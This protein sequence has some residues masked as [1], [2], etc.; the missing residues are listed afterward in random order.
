MSGR[1]WPSRGGSLPARPIKS[2]GSSARKTR[3][4]PSIRRMKSPRPANSGRRP[5]LCRRSS[6]RRSQSRRRKRNRRR[7]SSRFRTKL[8]A[9]EHRPA[10][11]PGRRGTPGGRPRGT[12]GNPIDHHRDAGAVRHQCGARRYHARADDHPVRGLPGQGGAGLIRSPRWSVTSPGPRGPSGSTFS[13]PFPGRTRSASRSRT[14]A[15]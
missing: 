8:H 11:E 5:G 13:H 12:Q 15:R 1:S 4:P 7:R 3:C 2:S 10:R 6:T 9:A 14:R